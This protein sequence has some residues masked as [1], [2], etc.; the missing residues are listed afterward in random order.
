MRLYQ[1]FGVLLLAYVAMALPSD[2]GRSSTVTTVSIVKQFGYPI[3]EHVV[4]T[5]D[6]YI[7]TM[8]RI[9][10]SKQTGN[11]GSK[12]PVIFL[13]HGLLCSSSDWVLSGPENGLAF[14]LS[15]A[16]YDVW[17]GNA[18]GNTYSRKHASKSPL[19]SPFWDFEWHDIGIYDLPA[20][21]DNVLYQTGEESLQYVGHSQGTTSFFVLNTMIPRFKNRIRSAHLLAPVVWMDHMES[22]LAKV[23]GPLLGQPNAFIELFGN[24]EFLPNTYAMQLMGSLMCR[25]SSAVQALCSNALFLMGGWDSP[26]LNATMIPDIMATTPAGCSINQIY[27]YL[28]E[29]N[30]GFFRQFDYGSTRNKKKYSIKTPPTYDVEAVDVPIYLYY[31]DNDYFASLIDVDRLRYTLNPSILKRAYRLPEEKWNHLDFLWGMGIK[32]ILYDLVMED[33]A[34]A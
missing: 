18:R 33:I 14:L 15:D 3:E 13:M 22:P 12:R 1:I 34:N 21:I 30:S 28:Q 10:Y 11:D 31:S 20:M 4:Q 29:Y 23:G 19:L 16:G 24:A 9:P 32:E 27:H 26:Y 8:H 7:L 25:D 2:A 6:G 5:S 17:M